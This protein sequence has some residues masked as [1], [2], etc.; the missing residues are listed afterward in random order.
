MPE[1]RPSADL[2]NSYTE[3]SDYCHTTGKPVYITRNGRSDLV[4]VSPEVFD[5]VCSGLQE[6]HYMDNGISKPLTEE[7]LCQLIAKSWQDIEAGRL[8]PLSEGMAQVRERLNN[9]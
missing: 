6:Y 5:R 2:R 7:K 9:V 3:I 4:V 1:I 8:S